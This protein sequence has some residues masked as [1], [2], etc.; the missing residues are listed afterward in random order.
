M[1]GRLWSSVACHSGFCKGVYHPS[2]SLF[3][4]LLLFIWTPE[5]K[6]LSLLLGAMLLSCTCHAETRSLRKTLVDPALFT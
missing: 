3:S 1:G 6:S 2:A 4:P 5:V